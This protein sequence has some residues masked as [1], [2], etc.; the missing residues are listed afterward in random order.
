[1]GSALRNPFLSAG[2]WHRIERYSRSGVESILLPF[3]ARDELQITAWVDEVYVDSTPQRVEIGNHID[4]RSCTKR[5]PQPAEHW[6]D[7]EIV[8]ILNK[9]DQLTGDAAYG[10]IVDESGIAKALGRI[11]TWT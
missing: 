1:M 10:F 3:F 6:S 4:W 2:V 8:V 11:G 7:D 5:S 9:G